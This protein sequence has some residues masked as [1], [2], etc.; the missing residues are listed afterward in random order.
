MRIVIFSPT[1]SY[2]S[3]SLPTLTDADHVIVVS[4]AGTGRPSEDRITVPQGAIGA[5][6]SAAARGSV[7]LRT[8]VR[9]MP[10][11]TGARFWRATRHVARVRDAVRSAD[12][13][14]APERDG[15]YAAWS[16]RRVALRHG[17]EVP[18]VSGYP[19]ARTAIGQLR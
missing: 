10:T 11:D 3:E 5:R 9:I 13:L 15:G 2:T 7:L 17:R 18:A 8:M 6:F 1:G 4:W 14:V 19:A 12:L 16:W